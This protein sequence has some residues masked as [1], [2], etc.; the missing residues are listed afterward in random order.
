MLNNVGWY[1][2]LLGDYQ[3]AGAFRQRSLIL[4][5]ELGDRE[6][7][8]NIWD[9]LGY[10]EHHLG[11]LAEAAACSQRALSIAKGAGRPRRRSS[12]GPHPPG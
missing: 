1:H 3:Q 4:N 7:E 5:A 10:A 8:G 11:N 6:L 2:G 12:K 9:S